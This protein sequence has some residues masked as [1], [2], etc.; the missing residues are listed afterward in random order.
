MSELLELEQLK[1]ELSDFLFGASHP[2]RKEVE[3]DGVWMLLA[4][5]A[6]VRARFAYR[7]ECERKDL[8]RAHFVLAGGLIEFESAAPSLPLAVARAI[9]QAHLTF[10]ASQAEISLREML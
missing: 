6:M 1:R 3:D 4:N 7:S 9:N 5:D 2:H 10:R 8:Y